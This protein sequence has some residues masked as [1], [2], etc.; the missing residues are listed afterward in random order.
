MELAFTALGS[1]R[2]M[3][4]IYRLRCERNQE[5]LREQRYG[6]YLLAFFVKV[7]C[8]TAIFFRY[9]IDVFLLI[10]VKIYIN[11]SLVK[12]AYKKGREPEM[13]S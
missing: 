6:I 11:D 2:P 8:C 10:L 3:E 13:T 9:Q 4:L 5:R 7:F 1:Q 12:F